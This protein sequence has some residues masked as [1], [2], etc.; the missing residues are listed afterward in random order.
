MA[1]TEALEAHRREIEA[2]TE[3]LLRP[4]IARIEAGFVVKEPKEFNDPIWGTIRLDPLEVTILD[5]PLLQRLRRIRQLGVV[6]LVYMAATHTRL[7]HSL[8]VVH[9]I[10]Q[11]VDSLNTRKVAGTLGSPVPIDERLR[12]TLRLAGLCHDV[13]HGAMSH[14][15]E[16]ALEGNRECRD[17]INA[18]QDHADL[19]HDSQLSE[20]AAYFM[21]GSP[22]FRE[23]LKSA[24]EVLGLAPNP[25]QADS[26]QELIVGKRIDD[27]LILIHEMISGP[28]DADKLDYLA[29]DAT[30]CGVPVVT[31]VTR[32]IQKVRATRAFSKD[33]PSAM[34]RRLRSDHN[35]YVVTGLARSGGSTLMELALARVL[36]FDKVY[37]HHAVRA[38]ESMVFEIV[39]RLAALAPCPP[40]LVPLRLSDEQ[41]LDM[42]PQSVAQF[43]G[44]EVENLAPAATSEVET[45]AD[46]AARLRERR[47]FVR[48]F[49]IAGTMTNDVYKDDEEHTNGLR[50]FLQD[51]G[52]WSK[53][54]GIKAAVVERL[55][56]VMRRLEMNE[57]VA[58]FEPNLEAYLQ[59]SPPK[60]A[61]KTLGTDTDHAFL[62]DEDGK[63]TSFHDDAPETAG[64]SDAYIATHDLGHAFCPVELAPYVFLAM[65]AELRVTHKIRLP[66]SMLPYAKQNSSQLTE[67]RRRL[68]ESGYYDDLPA[69]LR[70]DPAAFDQAGFASRVEE[71]VRKLDGYSGPTDRATA[72]RFGRPAQATARVR[73]FLKQFDN[74]ADALVDLA[75]DVLTH[76]RQLSRSDV[77]D[78]LNGFLRTHEDF[79]GSVLCVLGST[80]DSSSIF[81]NLAIDTASE[82]GVEVK[83]LTSAL[84]DVR[85]II[86]IDD[87]IGRGSQTKD[88]LQ[89]WL[90]LERTEA[91]GE[92]RD[93]LHDPQKDS[94]R[95]RKLGFVYVAGLAEGPPELKR[96]LTEV[97]LDGAVH[98]HI[99][100]DEI[101]TL[102]RVIQDR[103][104][105]ECFRTFLRA[106]GRGALAQHHGEQRTADWLAE[107]ELGYGNK[108]LLFT[109][110][111]NTPTVSLTALW[112]GGDGT[113]WQPIFP[114]RSKN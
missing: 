16:Y 39:N 61:P 29:R 89:A 56:E 21:L 85:P 70:P 47:L 53:R 38:A 114:R 12:E 84:E 50:L 5:S 67:L 113:S 60:S 22:A 69:D 111:F 66:S 71:V 74:G 112:A 95:A 105:A 13:G 15:S 34:Q 8:G 79:H 99:H 106:A 98:V 59:L 17:I 64:W 68:R 110:M 80:K 14:V 82:F 51:F 73:D 94:L 4:Y 87:F 18:F 57:T 54:E 7:E 72:T 23:M 48:G 31:D 11:V 35:G 102:D 63:L 97:G 43:I 19:S 109:S 27:Q 75:L 78:A 1:P 41:L 2:F 86:F 32:L 52:K 20:M 44:Q 36:M 10:Q 58:Q 24:R 101:P 40:G 45:I 65:E 62:I 25:A 96:F 81:A 42:T 88:I 3:S 46:L 104:Y 100:E 103:P 91:L 6:H 92:Q 76:V 28:Y 33:L 83:D 93:E 26:L 108:G 49:A 90:G 55:R 37:R 77:S 9:Q 30:M 107:R